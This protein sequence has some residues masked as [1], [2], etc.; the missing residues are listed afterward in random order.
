MCDKVITYEEC[1][2]VLSNAKTGKSPG[3]DGLTFEFYK[4]FWTHL[5]HIMVRIFNHSLSDRRLS[6]SQGRAVISL[7]HKKGKKELLSN[8]RPISLLNTDYKSWLQ[9]WPTG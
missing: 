2:K 3:P 4:T 8:W 9:F 1:L 7:L 5:Q 6:T